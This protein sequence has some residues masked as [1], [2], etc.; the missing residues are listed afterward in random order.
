MSKH[1]SVFHSILLKFFQTTDEWRCFHCDQSQGGRKELHDH[2]RTQ[3]L[4]N[5]RKQNYCK[6]CHELFSTVSSEALSLSSHF[7]LNIL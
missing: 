4:D 7:N 1:F 6:D 5:F 3:H 2:I